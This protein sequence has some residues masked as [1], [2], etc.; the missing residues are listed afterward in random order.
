MEVRSKRMEQS[1]QDQQQELKRVY[2]QRIIC[3]EKDFEDKLNLMRDG[4]LKAESN[5]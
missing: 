1:N 2:E 4:L 5:C 3:N